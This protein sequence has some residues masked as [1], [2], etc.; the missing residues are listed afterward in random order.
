MEKFI[1]DNKKNRIRYHHLMCIPRYIGEGYSD[2][3]CN[4]LANIKSNIKKNNYILVNG[5]D[6]V[7]TCCPNNVNGKCLDEIKVSRY[8]KLVKEKLDKGEKINPKEI[9][10]DCCWYYICKNIDV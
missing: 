5:L 7:C 6:D 1:M 10:N 3:F 9:C 2:E 4:N 8:D